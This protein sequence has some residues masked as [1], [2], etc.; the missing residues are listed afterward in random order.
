MRILYY[1]TFGAGSNQFKY[2]KSNNKCSIPQEY[3]SFDVPFEL[4]RLETTFNLRK[5][6][7]TKINKIQDTRKHKSYSIQYFM[8]Y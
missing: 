7:T 1:V 8:E 4:L 3:L 5:A 6:F 2:F